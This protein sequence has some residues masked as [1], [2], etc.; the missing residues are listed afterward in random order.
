M[1]L[2]LAELQRIVDTLVDNGVC[3]AS[4][5]GG[6]PL[7]HPHLLELARYASGRGLQVSMNTNGYLVTEE[8]ARRLK[9]AGFASV[10]VSI[11]AHQA[12]LHDAFRDR[13][14]SF[15]RAVRALDL[16]RSAGL[17]CTMSSVVSQ[18]NHRH[19][20]QLVSLAA[21]HGVAQLFLHNY[22][23]AGS[24]LANRSELDLSPVEWREFYQAA[25]RVQTSHPELP[26]SFDD[27]VMASLP[28]YDHRPLVKGSTCGKVSLNIRPDGSLTPCGF[29][30]VVIGNILEDGLAQL[31]HESPVL[32]ALRTKRPTGKCAR[33]GSW[34]DCQGGCSARAFALEGQFEAPDP[35]CWVG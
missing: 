6:E 12:A 28:G 24:G 19:L 9:E 4:F 29:I 10:G 26:L 3:F 33:C 5:G 22:K 8:V 23:C 14:G 20:D 27:P 1:E 7:I 16:L 35:H 30:P 32:T 15:V 13:P 17:K 18:L 21:Q 11:D 25:L 31:W 2:S 34:A